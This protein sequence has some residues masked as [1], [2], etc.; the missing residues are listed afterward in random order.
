MYKSEM[1]RKYTNYL[2][3][4]S[5]SMNYAPNNV[6]NIKKRSKYFQLKSEVQMHLDEILHQQDFLN[7]VIKQQLHK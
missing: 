7:Q 3:E 2:D 6:R 1:N 5:F 4:V